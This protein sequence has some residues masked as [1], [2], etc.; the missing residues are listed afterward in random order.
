[1]RILL[2]PNAYAA[3][4]GEPV[5]A[6]WI[7]STCLPRLP[8][9]MRRPFR[10]GLILVLATIAV[11]AAA[12]L[13][14]PL[15]VTV[16]LGWPLLFAIYVWQT[17]VFRDLPLRVP[18]GA[19][20][21]GAGLGLVWWL[22]AGRWLADSYDVSTGSALMLA[23][24]LNVGVL[25]TAGGAV[26][27]LVPAVL[28]RLAGV[29]VRESLDGFAVGALGALGYLTASV[30]A[31]VGPQIVEG[32]VEER[33]ARHLLEDAITYGVVSPITAIAAG[34]LVGMCLWFTP[35]RRS[36]R[37]PERARRALLLC[38]AL[39]TPLY[40]A[41][42]A[43]DA[44]TLPRVLDLAIKLGLAVLA[45]LLV[46][47]AVQIAL[48]HEAPDPATGAPLLCPHCERVV[49]DLPFCSAC[50][51]AARASSRTSRRRRRES[52]PVRALDRKV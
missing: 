40:L 50:G 18:A 51:V 14:G 10:L 30:T 13:T 26:L 7:S 1:M 35:D 4:S 16:T 20:L 15:G 27:M 29:P 9:P 6:P 34:G 52:P 44:L 17:D 23:K 3:A 43:V 42:W 21:L 36:G 37:D 28:T 47:C 19:A 45:L 25:F 11:L 39:G 12:Q 46:R 32:L 41:V 8:G 31:I 38:T 2:R 5:W 49:P 48:L 24:V 33:D 22:F